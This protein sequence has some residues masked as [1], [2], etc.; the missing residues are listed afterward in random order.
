MS[1]QR[2]AV[3]CPRCG[4][5]WSLNLSELD[6][7]DQLIYKGRGQQKTY[8]APCPRCGTRVVIKVAFEEEEGD[9]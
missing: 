7:T 3:T 4:Q 2:L 1:E 9:G 8:R 5:A 6:E